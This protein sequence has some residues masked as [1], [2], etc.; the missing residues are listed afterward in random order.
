MQRKIEA[1]LE[2][3][4]EAEIAGTV[5]IKISHHRYCTKILLK[6]AVLSTK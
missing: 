4:D 3:K 5:Y 2:P 6:Y 1:I